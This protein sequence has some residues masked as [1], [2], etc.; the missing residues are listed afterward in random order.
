MKGSL[1]KS[2][3]GGPLLR[4]KPIREWIAH[5]TDKSRRYLRITNPTAESDADD[6]HDTA[7]P[8]VEMDDDSDLEKAIAASLEQHE[9]ETHQDTATALKE[10]VGP[11]MQKGLD[12]SIALEGTANA[13]FHNQFAEVNISMAMMEEEKAYVNN[14]IIDASKAEEE[15][16]LE[17]AIW[18]SMKESPDKKRKCSSQSFPDDGSSEECGMRT[19]ERGWMTPKGGEKRSCKRCKLVLHC[20]ALVRG[21]DRHAVSSPKKVAGR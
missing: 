15:A 5:P 7:K 6:E 3:D 16:D 21:S 8:T 18:E 17:R 1:S 19:A 10:N 12:G 20:G 13:D 4:T 9:H 14:A 2:D 11:D